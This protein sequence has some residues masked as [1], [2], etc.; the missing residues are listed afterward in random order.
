MNLFMWIIHFCVAAV[1]SHAWISCLA[2]RSRTDIST[3]KKLGFHQNTLPK[4]H[5]STLLLIILKL[6][7]Q[8]CHHIVY[9]IIVSFIMQIWFLCS[10]AALFLES[11]WLFFKYKL[12]VLPPSWTLQFNLV[13]Y[14]NMMT[15]DSWWDVTVVMLVLF[16]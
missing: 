12:A 11:Y 10:I 2:G 16:I 8:I 9:L 7:L 14:Y 4:F 1:I 15:F 6:L 5:L 13:V 3:F